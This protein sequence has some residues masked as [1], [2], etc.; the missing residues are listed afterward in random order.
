MSSH[1]PLLTLTHF[2]YYS[3]GMPPRRQPNRAVLLNSDF[4]SS[5]TQGR[6]SEISANTACGQLEIWFRSLRRISD[7]DATAK[8]IITALFGETVTSDDDVTWE[9]LKYENFNV[10]HF[11][12][13]AKWLAMDAR[14]R[15]PGKED[16]LL[17]W[18]SADRYLSALK[19]AVINQCKNMTPSMT[20]PLSNS[21]DTK[22]VRDGMEAI[23]NDRHRQDG[24]MLVLSLFVGA[25]V[26]C[27]LNQNLSS[28]F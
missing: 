9:K 14:N 21:D 25:L 5:H 12:R 19:K 2:L 1:I 24:T 8:S 26:A 11:D 23:Y 6:E 28:L 13:F 10:S 17:K 15:L 4:A 27:L 7:A 16:E 18:N 22:Q 20:S 3:T